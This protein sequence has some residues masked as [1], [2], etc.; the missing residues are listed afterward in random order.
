VG[1]KL[2]NILMAPGRAMDQGMTT[3]QAIPWAGDTAMMM[4]GIGAP[5][6]PSGALG[7]FGGRPPRIFN[8]TSEWMPGLP[9]ISGENM[10]QVAPMTPGGWF[11]PQPKYNQTHGQL[12]PANHPTDN[13]LAA[14]QE[15]LKSAP[16]ESKSS[17]GIL[18][19]LLDWFKNR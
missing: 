5:N 8:N 19:S 2:A 14:I 10:P 15:V 1:Q 18:G 17:G 6:A 16:S 7:A 9:K 11:Y 13:A 3:E 4:G 12:T